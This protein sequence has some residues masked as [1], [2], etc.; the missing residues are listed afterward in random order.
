[1]YSCGC[2]SDAERPGS[3][4]DIDDGTSETEEE[5]EDSVQREE[6]N[7]D[8]EEAH[9]WNAHRREWVEIDHLSVDAAVN[10]YT[11]ITELKWGTTLEGAEKSTEYYFYLMFPMDSIPSIL[12][13]TNI[14]LLAKKK[15][16][17]SKRELIK[18]LG[19]RL[20]MAVEPRRGPLPESESDAGVVSTAANYEGCCGM[21]LSRFTDINSCLQLAEEPKPQP[22]NGTCILPN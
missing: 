3:D 7:Q 17:L 20:A 6:S 12:D 19:I 5:R 18:W 11:G 2:E 15:A 1:M 8:A 21:K 10:A 13:Y 9:Y 16:P 4:S 22:V 14:N